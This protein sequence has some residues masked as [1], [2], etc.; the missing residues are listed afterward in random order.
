MIAEYM[1]SNAIPL[2]QYI[3]NRGYLTLY[4]DPGSIVS[5]TEKKCLLIV[6]YDYLLIDCTKLIFYILC[7]IFMEGLSMI[8]ATQSSEIIV[9]DLNGMIYSHCPY[10]IFNLSILFYFSNFILVF[11]YYKILLS[12]QW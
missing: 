6:V 12:N 7:A 1:R 5:I 4:R 11:K 9:I 3:K 2:C 8:K 10:H